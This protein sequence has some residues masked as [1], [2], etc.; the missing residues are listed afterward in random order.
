MVYKKQPPRQEQSTYSPYYYPNFSRYNYPSRIGDEEVY[1]EPKFSFPHWDDEVSGY[2]PLTRRRRASF[3]TITTINGNVEENI[4]TS[5]TTNNQE[6]ANNQEVEQEDEGETT[7]DKIQT[8]IELA[9]RDQKTDY[10]QFRRTHATL[11]DDIRALQ[12]EIEEIEAL[13]MSS[14]WNSIKDRDARRQSEPSSTVTGSLMAAVVSGPGR[15]SSTSATAAASAARGQRKKRP[16]RA[17]SFSGNN[18]NRCIG[19]EDGWS[20][21]KVHQNEWIR[22]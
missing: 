1:T 10:D 21:E 2:T 20:Q 4:N 6:I 9:R 19:A 5:L 15:L 13:C 14:G 22:C 11:H 8:D 16:N 18:T 12:R 3:S 7:C 17:E